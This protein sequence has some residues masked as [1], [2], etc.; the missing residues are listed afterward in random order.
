MA[1]RMSG[2]F[3]EVWPR[4]TWQHGVGVEDICFAELGAVD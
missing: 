3:A 1:A 4:R 2:A